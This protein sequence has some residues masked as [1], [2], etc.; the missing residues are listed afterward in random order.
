MTLAHSAPDA[1]LALCRFPAEGPVTLAVSGGP[2]SMALLV[3]AA[4]AG[5]GGLVVHVDHGLRPGSAAEADVVARAARRF[6]FGF[7]GRRVEVAPGADLE[8]RARRARYGVLPSGVLTGHTMD[9]LAAT[10]LL[11]LLRGGALDGLAAMSRSGPLGLGAVVR[12]LLGL[13]R[14]DTVAVCERAGIETVD[15]PSNRDVRFRRNRL[16]AEGIPLLADIAGRDVVPVLARQ[17]A[18]AADDVE[19]LESLAGDIDPTDVVALRSAPAAL[20]RRAV[21]SWL[22]S[23]PEQHPPSAAEVA[24]VL[25]VAHGHHQACEVSGGRRVARRAGQL[26]L[27]SGSAA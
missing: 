5:L 15:D 14:S 19:L 21:R 26:T 18:L 6:G 22:R 7:E 13:R 16:R 17:A 1:V 27:D 24:R 9:D 2:D 23:G 25:D 3:L 4:D 8:A 20:A 12:P 11:N 10:V